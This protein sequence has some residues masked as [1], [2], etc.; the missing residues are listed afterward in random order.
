MNARPVTERI[1][2]P[3]A[4]GELGVDLDELGVRGL[5]VSELSG[6]TSLFVS[7]KFDELSSS[8]GTFAGCLGMVS[9]LFELE[10]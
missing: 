2:E 10:L 6:D 1:V 7:L 9:K 5:S 8:D 3:L 4:N